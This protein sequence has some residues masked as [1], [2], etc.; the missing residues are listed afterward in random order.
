VKSMGVNHATILKRANK[1]GWQR[2]LTEQVRT[3]TKAKVTGIDSDNEPV[4]T[5]VVDYLCSETLWISQTYLF[6]PAGTVSFEPAKQRP[7]VV[8]IYT[9]KCDFV[10]H[11]AMICVTKLHTGGIMALTKLRQQGGAVVLTIPSDIAARAGWSV[12]TLL[13]VTADGDAVSIKPSG[14]VARGR[15]TLSQLLAGIDEAEIRQFNEDIS[16]GTN[17]T[18]QG[19]ELI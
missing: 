16:D 17:D 2:D 12:G 15:K 9:A 14:R 19:R 13:D 10:P 7:L 8:N 11:H 1:E 5:V 4:E 3:A 6:E 18:P